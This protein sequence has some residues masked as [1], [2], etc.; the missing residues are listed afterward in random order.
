[1]SYLRWTSVWV[2]AAT[3]VLGDDGSLFLNVGNKPTQPW[4]AIDVVLEARRHL[5]LQNTIHWIKS[6]VIDR[7]LAGARA[8]LER[9]LAVGH[10]KPINSERFLNDCHEFVFHLTP[11]GRTPLDRRAIG[12]PYQD[13]SNVG[14][15]QAA[16]EGPLP[17]QQLVHPLHHDSEPRARPPASGDLSRRCSP[18]YCLRV[19]GLQR[20]RVVLYPFMGIGSTA[21][22]CA[23]LGLDFV[24]IEMDRTYLDEAVERVKEALKLRKKRRG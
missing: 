20:A 19:H 23:K 21:V 13:P 9:D 1:M 2:A 4:T 16:S 15:W 7:E 10:Y 5:I 6:I 17:R 24:G 12:V 18:E 3:R 8:G 14:R 22:A 11:R